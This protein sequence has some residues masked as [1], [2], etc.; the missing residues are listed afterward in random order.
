MP[1][2]YSRLSNGDTFDAASLND[3]FS[4]VESSLNALTKSDVRESAFGRDHLPSLATSTPQTTTVQVMGGS[5]YH[6]YTR[7][8]AAY[9][10]WGAGSG[11]WTVIDSSG[12]GGGG[13]DL[14]VIL[15]ETPT[16]DE[17][18][19]GVLVLMNV[20]VRSLMDVG[21]SSTL[22]QEDFYAVVAIQVYAGS[23]WYHINRTERYLQGNTI[24]GITGDPSEQKNLWYD[25]PVR[26]VIKAADVSNDSITKV[27]GVVGI[28]KVTAGTATAADH[29]LRLNRCTLTAIPLHGKLT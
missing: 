22:S 5:P 17:K 2:T 3:R 18:Y 16:S 28:A 15:A 14:E 8:N 9:P 12:G 10:G 24:N 29:Q 25:I 7:A 26:T 11:S 13:T 1:I 20:Q 23:T 6:T 21:T 19:G 27:R 4:S